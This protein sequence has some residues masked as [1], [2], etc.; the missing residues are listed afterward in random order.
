MRVCSS[1]STDISSLVALKSYTLQL[2]C[3]VHCVCSVYF[4]LVCCNILFS[5]LVF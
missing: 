4:G 1:Q 3:V 2:L 5:V